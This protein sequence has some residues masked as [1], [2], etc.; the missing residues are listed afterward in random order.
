M[1]FLRFNLVFSNFFCLI[2]LFIAVINIIYAQI[3]HVNTVIK[4]ISIVQWFDIPIL[5][6]K[7]INKTI[8]NTVKNNK[9]HFVK[10][11][12]SNFYFT[13]KF[14]TF[15]L[16]VFKKIFYNIIHVKI[17]IY[18]FIYFK[19]IYKYNNSFFI[20]K[21]MFIQQCLRKIFSF[22][23]SIIL[24]NINVFHLKRFINN[25]CVTNNFD[26][27]YFKAVVLKI[28]TSI[29]YIFLKRSIKIFQDSLLSIDFFHFNFINNTKIEKKNIYYVLI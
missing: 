5:L 22:K 24:L 6:S 21:I 17:K 1:I 7:K 14:E 29:S 20:Y 2:Y 13:V 8:T 3:I 10:L 9:T 11:N 15:V 26:I 27:L 12:F 18:D 16:S 19:S 23:S 28:I 4:R 25:K